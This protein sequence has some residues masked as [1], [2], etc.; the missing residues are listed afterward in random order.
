LGCSAEPRLPHPVPNE[1]HVW[2]VRLDGSFAQVAAILSADEIARARRFRFARDRN[3]F[4][5]GRAQLRT[6]LAA[7]TGVAPARLRFAYGL[8][9]KPSAPETGLTFNMSHSHDRAV[10]AVGDGLELGIDIEKLQAAGWTDEVAEQ[11]FSPAEVAVLRALPCATRPAAF[12][13]CWTRK[14]A[15][16][17]ARGDGL[18][19]PLRDF[20]VTLAPGLEPEVLRTAWSAAE[21][22]DWRLFDLSAH[23]AGYVAALAVHAHDAV[24]TVRRDHPPG[25]LGA[26]AFQHSALSSTAP[27]ADTAT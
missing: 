15:F 13:S 27:S 12:L 5:V 10:L 2:F 21:P 20:D 4:A 22:A 6:L 19:L 17:K 24:V 11:F 25:V 26:S 14:E 8:Y 16:I 9:G 3:R 1:A 18:S 23:C 7:Y